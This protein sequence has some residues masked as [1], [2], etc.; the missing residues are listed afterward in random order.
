MISECRIC[1]YRWQNMLERAH[2]WTLPLRINGH[3]M[4]YNIT[5]FHI[6]PI[7]DYAFTFIAKMY[8]NM[9]FMCLFPMFFP[10][11]SVECQSKQLKLS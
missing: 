2:I 5:P 11:I 8:S 9:F 10:L 7:Y 1:T 4:I 6:A 3:S